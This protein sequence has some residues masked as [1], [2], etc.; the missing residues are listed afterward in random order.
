M[1]RDR[2]GS[3]TKEGLVRRTELLLK[4]N[5]LVNASR[6]E[7]KEAYDRLKQAFENNDFNEI[8]SIHEECFDNVIDLRKKVLNLEHKLWKAS[9]TIITVSP[10]RSERK[11]VNEGI[12]NTEDRTSN[13]N[14]NHS[15]VINMEPV[16]V[17]LMQ[18]NQEN[19][20]NLEIENFEIGLP[21]SRA[22]TNIRFKLHGIDDIKTPCRVI[23]PKVKRIKHK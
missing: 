22:P 17:K 2:K 6:R 20:N 13:E 5:A 16:E 10:S 19:P 23:F 18:P 1:F 15:E 14:M 11:I 9:R 12:N 8:F 3:F 7:K 4:R 21:P